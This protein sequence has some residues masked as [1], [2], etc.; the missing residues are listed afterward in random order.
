VMSKKLKTSQWL[1]P[2]RPRRQHN[3]DGRWPSAVFQA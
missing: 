3:G 1:K 2:L